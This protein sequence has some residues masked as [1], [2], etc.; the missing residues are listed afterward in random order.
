MKKFVACLAVLACV[1]PSARA[2]TIDFGGPYVVTI[3]APGGQGEII[4]IPLAV[5][6]AGRPTFDTIDLAIGS[7]TV[8][9]IP[10]SDPVPTSPIDGSWAYSPQVI[11]LVVEAA[12]PLGQPLAIDGLLSSTANGVYPEGL[13]AIGASFILGAPS[14]VFPL[15]TLTIDTTGLAVGD[16]FLYIGDQVARGDGPGDPLGR[17]GGFSK[18]AFNSDGTS[19]PLMG[20]GVITVV[21]EP[22]TLALLG[23]GAIGFIARRKKA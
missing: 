9:M 14:P 12:F 7:D 11:A 10:D 8:P 22:A 19:E 16:H 21:P 18:I 15:G 20:T 2:A 3:S 4:Q 17:D 5:T 23:L 1:A 6:S 13:R